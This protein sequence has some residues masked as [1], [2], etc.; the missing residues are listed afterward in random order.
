MSRII[1]ITASGAKNL[2]LAGKFQGKLSELGHESETLNL[3][4]LNLPLYSSLAEAEHSPSEL[5]GPWMEKLKHADAM[6][7]LAPEYN[8]GIP[9]VLT[10][11]IAWVSRS[12]KS[13]RECFNGKCAALGTHSGG[14]GFHVL[15]ALRLQL[16]YIGMNVIGRQIMTHSSK[17]L[18]ESSLE[19]ACKQ[20]V[21]SL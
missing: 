12:S 19:D 20:L 6:V 3:L 5:L 18:D 13:W 9:P 2:E 7:F 14:G 1:V 16:S 21:K 11:F 4:S 10:N 8:G 15:S 17:P